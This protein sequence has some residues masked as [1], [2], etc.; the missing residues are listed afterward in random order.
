MWLSS[1]HSSYKAQFPSSV[2]FFFSFFFLAVFCL[3]PQNG[4]S[5]NVLVQRREFHENSFKRLRERPLPAG[6]RHDS[7]PDRVLSA[8]WALGLS[9]HAPV[10]RR[11]LGT[12]RCLAHPF[13]HGVQKRVLLWFGNSRGWRCSWIAHRFPTWPLNAFLPG[14]HGSNLL[15]MALE[16][17]TKLHLYSVT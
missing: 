9:V 2:P 3:W 4:T 12:Q 16:E 8:A 1:S 11:A 10:P 15:L 7:R 6:G 13:S 14:L 5:I 17:K